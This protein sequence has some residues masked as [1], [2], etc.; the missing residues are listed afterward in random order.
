M[1]LVDNCPICHSRD[2]IKLKNYLFKKSTYPESSRVRLIF[3]EILKNKENCNFYVNFCQKC[4]FIFLNPRFSEDDYKIIFKTKEMNITADLKEYQRFSKAYK[5]INKFYKT[6]FQ[7]KPKVLDYGGQNGSFLIP[8]IKNY[9]CFL[10]DYY[11]YKL[12]KFIQYLGR[13]SDDLKGNDI[14]DI[15]FSIRVLE[16]VNN[17]RELITDLVNN[18]HEDGILYIQVPFG[19]LNEWRSLYHPVSHINFFSEESLYKCLKLSG[20]NV[21]Y[22]KTSFYR[23]KKR[24]AGWKIDIVGTKRKK[25]K[26]KIISQVSSTKLQQLKLF[27]YFILLFRKK[28]IKFSYIKSKIKQITRKT[29]KK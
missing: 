1:K 18:L 8:Y 13:N 2:L 10:I 4:G 26:D 7:N 17:P 5:L 24:T 12:P 27:Y 25:E 23:T 9:K 15:I 28:T 6:N 16:H 11:K 14:F 22:L 3:T 19:C 29:F 20:L 21:I